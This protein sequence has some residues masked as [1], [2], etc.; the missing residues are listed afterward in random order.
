MLEGQLSY[1]GKGPS[2]TEISGQSGRFYSETICFCQVV[3]SS[4]RVRNSSVGDQIVAALDQFELV[5]LNTV[6]PFE[7]VICKTL[8][9][10]MRGRR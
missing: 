5:W 4:K 7:V 8:K 1:F 9:L 2:I 6:N 10:C 3:L